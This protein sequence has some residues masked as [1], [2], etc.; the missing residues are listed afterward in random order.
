MGHL[1]LGYLFPVKGTPESV[2]VRVFLYTDF[3]SFQIFL[4]CAWSSVSM[5]KTG[6]LLTSVLFRQLALETGLDFTELH[7]QKTLKFGCN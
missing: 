5:L 2:I 7:P 4:F 3:S 6:S 1:L